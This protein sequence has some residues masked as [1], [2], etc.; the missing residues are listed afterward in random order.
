[1]SETVRHIG[2]L[3]EI[4]LEGLTPEQWIENECERL[5]V[6]DKYGDGAITALND[7]HY[8]KGDMGGCYKYIVANGRLFEVLQD[9][10]EDDYEEISILTP[11]ADGTYSYVM[12]F[13]NGGAC[14]EE[15]LEC[16]LKKL[17]K[18]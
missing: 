13:Y 7:Y 1:M 16:E 11:N 14:L 17:P 10:A 8:G 6:I 2:K 9:R 15:M 12:Q 18:P 4:E 3:R 5:G